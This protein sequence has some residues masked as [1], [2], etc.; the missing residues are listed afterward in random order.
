[1]V[2]LR[3]RVRLPARASRFLGFL[4]FLLLWVPLPVLSVLLLLSASGDVVLHAQGARRP[5]SVIAYG[6]NYLHNYLIPPAPSATPFAPVWA[7]DGERIAFSLH[8]SIWVASL[9]DGSAREVAGGGGRMSA[10]PAAAGGAAAPAAEPGA[11]GGAVASAGQS[12]A[13]RKYL[14]SPAWSPD[15]RWLVYTADDG[16]KSIEL[17]VLEVA[18]GATWAL[19]SDGRAMLDPVFSPDGSRLAYVA[20]LPNGYLN[21]FV[22]GIADGR[23]TG[24]AVPITEDSTT[25]VPVERPYFTPQ[26][27]AIT[28]AWINDRELA[29]VSNH[30][31]ALGSGAIVRV[32]AERLGIRRA[33]RIVDEQTLYHARPALSR[34]GRLLAYVTSDGGREPRHSLVVRPLDAPAPSSSG[35]GPTSASAPASQAAPA[36]SPPSFSSS[37]SSPAS[38]SESAAVSGRRIAPSGYDL[39][40]PQWSPDGRRLLCLSNERGVADLAIVDVGTGAVQ[41]LSI[42]DLSYREPRARVTVAV[43]DAATR[44]IVPAR[45]HVRAS[46]G[47]FYA[48]TG[49]YAR[50]SW[51]G[52]RLFHTDGRFE[53]QVPAGRT[54]LRIVRG[55]EHVPA[56]VDVEAA[57]GEHRELDV[58]LDRVDDPTS[59]SQREGAGGRGVERE[60]RGMR[61]WRGWVGGS[62]GAHI[63]AG[64]LLLERLDALVAM[65]DAEAVAMVSNP[66]AHQPRDLTEADFWTRGG[67]PHRA[68]SAS[69]QL[70]LGQ[71]HRPPFFGH[72]MTFGAKGR[73]GSLIPVT[74]GYEPPPGSSLARTN[75]DVLREMRAR[76]AATSYVHAFAGEADPMQAG[77]GIGKAFPVDAALGLTD[78]LEWAAASRGSFVPWYAA[79]NNGLRVAAI[80]G[81]DSITNLHISRL[82]G[83][84]R[85]YA[86]LGDAPLTPTAWWDAVNA[87]R[88][89]VTTGPLVDLRVNGVGPGGEVALDTP[90]AGAPRV[91]RSASSSSAGDPV[92]ARR[93]PLRPAIVSVTANVRSITP[94][95][96]VQLVMNGQAV[97]DLP[98]DASR[99][100]V[101]WQGEVAVDRSGWLHLRAEGLPAERGPLDTIYAQAF[102]NP[103]W[104]T[105]GGLPPRDRASAEY[106]LRW[107]D[108]LQLMADAW[109][110]WTSA[111]ERAHVFGQFDEARAI[112]RRFAAEAPPSPPTTDGSSQV[113]DQDGARR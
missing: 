85:T 70:V 18:T 76:G 88:S 56:Q 84:V 10:A 35:A 45:V 99:T 46:D 26:D 34:D 48:P 16:G 43:R 104:L 112:Y 22:R 57:A 91:A 61:G 6:G 24:E 38:S 17:E 13:N 37:S 82:V 47:R 106:A 77:L 75:S 69:T 60:W 66:V 21:A 90:G 42:T 105:V 36:S 97:Q 93:P 64:G 83:C 50:V 58:V 74:I 68:S 39:F 20:A 67:A 8:G 100:R 30:G 113:R 108:R 87:G 53:L 92:L 94:L 2:R 107:I 81:E 1:M 7:P 62:T 23:W 102:T 40:R 29:I 109:P 15:G 27:M 86:Y 79:L 80:G 3:S 72:V 103:V 78:T 98:L 41:R 44:A 28:P 52:D 9:A 63:Q 111:Q 19:T 32:P 89:F 59:P 101:D 4:G 51:A 71:E 5:Y 96:R 54:R 73:L 49:S 12:A 11:K 95:Q 31:V 33:T 14:S 110:G 25:D 55:F 65:A